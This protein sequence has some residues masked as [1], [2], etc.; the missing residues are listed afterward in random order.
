M[1][2]LAPA[3]KNAPHLLKT[4][5]KYWVCHAKQLS[6]CHVTCWNVT[7]CHACHAK[8][9]YAKL[10]N[11]KSDTFCRTYH[12]HDHMVLT[13]TVADGCER[14]RNV[15][16]TQLY[17]HTPRVKQEP[18]LRI[19]E[20]LLISTIWLS[21]SGAKSPTIWL[22]FAQ[23]PL[24]DHHFQKWVKQYHKLP[25]TG[26]GKFIPPKPTHQNGDGW[27]MVYCCFTHSI[28]I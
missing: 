16:R 7:K 10:E 9:S 28:S 27:G 13:R 5:Q 19:R 4:W 12:R 24:V 26:N 22:S 14:L 17:P 20:K 11:S 6:T 8:R 23:N 3:A 15:W 1:G 21:S 18:L 25:M 2:G